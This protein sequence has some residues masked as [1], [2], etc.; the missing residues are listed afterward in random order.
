[1]GEVSGRIRGLEQVGGFSGKAVT[2][3][4]G[5]T[6]AH[7]SDFYKKTLASYAAI[8]PSVVRTAMQQWLR[9]PPLTITL[10]PGERE[11]YAEA[12]AVQPPRP[13]A[14]KTAGAVKGNRPLPPVGQLA[15]LDF[16]DIVHVRLSNGIPVDYVQRSGIPVT[17]VAMA[18]D[19]G[20]PADAPQGRGLAAMTM[21]L[22]DEGT[23][24]LSSQQIAETEERLGADVG[25]SNGADRSY[26][27]LNAL[28]P[29]LAPS[30]DLMSDVV[31]DPAF[32]RR[33]HRPHPRAGAD[34]DRADAEGPDAGCAAAAAGGA[35]WRQP[36][37]WRA[38]RRRPEGDRGVRPG[39]PRRL[40]AALAAARQC[41]DVRRL[42]P[43]AERD[44]AVA[45][46]ALRQ[47]GAAGGGEGREE[48]PARGA[49]AGEPEDPARQPARA[50]RSRA[51]SAAS[52]C[53]STRRATSSRSTRPTTC[54]AATSTRGS[55]WTCART[56]AGR[57][58]S[59][60]RSR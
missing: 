12:K 20:K 41:Q 9:R 17:Q 42:R 51:S 3:A 55:T 11:A 6:Y 36:S 40:R 45:R 49:A 44:P 47:L 13:G 15:A 58:A 46:S 16:P 10:S 53:R 52:C 38:R 35:V 48:L 31:K 57:T 33:R 26:V 18:F 28:S 21:D 24:K 39:R 14:D 5:Q 19:A 23:S 60:A 2:L 1:M 30:L 25:A 4:E 56:R 8:T 27:T 34:R 7:D 22:L 29:N 37:L 54:S 32:R 50:R 59:A 43:A